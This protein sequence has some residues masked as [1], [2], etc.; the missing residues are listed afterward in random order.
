VIGLVLAAAIYVRP[1]CALIAV[2]IGLILV[3]NRRSS[4]SFAKRCRALAVLTIAV[5]IP[6]VPWIVRDAS[7]TGG[8]L[9]PM[10][11][12]AA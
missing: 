4:W 10:R 12:R 11:R 9:V 1:E 7:V 8:K 6:L 5:V 2:P 3:L